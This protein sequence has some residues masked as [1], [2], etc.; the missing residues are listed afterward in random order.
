MKEPKD[1][2][3]EKR[4]ATCH[5]SK[6]TNNNKRSETIT[7]HF[8]IRFF[9]SYVITCLFR[10][11]LILLLCFGFFFGYLVISV[12]LYF[13]ISVFQNLYIFF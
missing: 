1:K 6:K 11:I 9:R 4:T 2:K 3:E 10:Y 12:V 7:Y 13:S 8:N 5:K